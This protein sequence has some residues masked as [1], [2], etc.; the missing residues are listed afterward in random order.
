MR[1]L[2]DENPYMIKDKEDLSD[3]K[4]QTRVALLEQSNRHISYGL[5]N[6]EKKID[7]VEHKIDKVE[8]TIY[9]NFK[10]FL[11]I[12]L[13]G[14]ISIASMGFSIYQYVKH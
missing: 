14:V 12:S 7:K 3:R 5:D 4:I 8:N 9:T 1:N 10:W 13:T 6:I 2:K 11:G